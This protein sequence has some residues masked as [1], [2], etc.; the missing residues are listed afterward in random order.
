MMNDL[1]F[2]MDSPE[3]TLAT[4]GGK[5]ES[6][7]QLTRA[8]FPVPRGFL[9]GTAA[10]R[11]FVQANDLQ[12]QIVA[13]ARSGAGTDYE[14][15]SKDIR[16][17]FERGSMPPEV[18]EAIR[19]AHAALR[20]EGETPC[21]V[22][23]RCSECHCADAACGPPGEKVPMAVR[24]S[25]TAEDLPGAS[26]AGQ[27]ETFL[28]IAGEQEVLLA[29]QRCWSS[30]WTP[31]ALA[32]RARQGIDPDTVSLAVVVQKMV[33]ASAAGVL[34]TANPLTGA[35]DEVVI[36]AA[37]GLG[38]AVVSGLV[39]PDHITADKV[40]GEVKQ[41]EVA[42]KTV[43]TAPTAG[44]TGERA[45]EADRRGSAVLDASRVA[46][47]VRLGAAVEAH[48]GAPQDIEWCLAD[49]R[50]WIV[51]SRPVTT[52][53]PEPVR[54]DSPVPGAKWMNDLQAA[55]WATEPLSPLAAT[56]TFAAMVTARQRKFQMQKSPWYVLINGW[57]YIRADFRLPATVTRCVWWAG[58]LAAGT[59]DRHRMV[60]RTWPPRLRVLDSLEK[61]EPANLSDADLH[62]RAARL[63]KELGWWW[64]E[65]TWGPAATIMC[66]QIIGKL[67]VP[68]L[69][70][71]VVLFRGNDSLLLEAERALRH[72][73]DTG[74]T[75]AYL[76][77]FGHFVESADPLHPTLRE[78]PELL[79][80]YLEMARHSRTGP[81]ERLARSR[82]QRTEAEGHVGALSGMRRV[83]AERILRGGQSH[84]AHVDDSVFHFQRVLALLRAAYLEVG[85]RLTGMGAVQ[86]AED[87]FYL[88]RRELTGPQDQLATRVA[89]R[90]ELRERHKRLAPPPF[91]PPRDDPAWGRDRTLRLFSSLM[92]ETVIRRGTQEREGRRVL[93]GTPGSP[94]RARGI[95]R[96]VT[97]PEDFRRF[98]P[99]DV[100][101]AHA[102]TPV[103]TP[104]FNIASAAVTEVGGNFSHAAIVAR[105]FGIPLVNGALDATRD[106]EEGTPVLVDGSAGIVEL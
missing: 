75:A 105:E 60:R 88:K 81:D 30:L 38:E 49:G 67:G 18:A 21:P 43:L 95:A 54:W 78:S 57:L 66:E 41:M 96:I 36:D 74:E 3:A 5:G 106:I 24:S 44:G 69:T 33:D 68:H 4:V 50:L 55:E 83:V 70:D 79:D 90:R 82:L 12:R 101:V 32:Y 94:G 2:S 64:W 17:L 45:V 37:W 99:G 93:V 10:Y 20:P 62:A 8:G 13:L 85:Q 34:F 72:A 103:W 9:I 16:R 26:F 86:R 53:P 63:L 48:Y 25:A 29:V 77:R 28:N 23:V 27:Q 71:P 19:Q 46:E 80:Q 98:Q 76:A 61:T 39:T 40:T 87:V 100:L 58:R 97:G 92:G 91:V 102:T 15:A 42:D 65:V 1:V 73:A 14:A 59:M 22:A 84:A 7:V 31:R 89:H 35:R 47:L 56:T 6:L 52:L 51:Q 104:L 11:K